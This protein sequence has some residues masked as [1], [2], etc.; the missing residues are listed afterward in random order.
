MLTSFDNVSMIFTLDFLFNSAYKMQPHT[1]C[2]QNHAETT[3]RRV[4]G[5]LGRFVEKRKN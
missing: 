3:K 2:K 1:N 4:K 5:S